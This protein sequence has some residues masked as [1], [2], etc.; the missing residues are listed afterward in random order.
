VG[1]CP[2]DVPDGVSRLPEPETVTMV[3]EPCRHAVL[4]MV[5][6][7]WRQASD[8]SMPEPVVSPCLD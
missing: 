1:A 7:R 5:N 8:L 2:G 4:N 6:S 3:C